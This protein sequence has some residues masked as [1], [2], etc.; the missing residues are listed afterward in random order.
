[1]LPLR[2]FTAV[3]TQEQQPLLIIKKARLEWGIWRMDQ[4]EEEIVLFGI[5]DRTNTI[6]IPVLTD[7]THQTLASWRWKVRIFGRTDTPF[8]LLASKPMYPVQYNRFGV[9][10]GRL[11]CVT[12]EACLLL[13]GIRSA[14]GFRQGGTCRGALHGNEWGCLLEAQ[15]VQLNRWQS[16]DAEQYQPYSLSAHIK[17]RQMQ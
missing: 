2:T 1:M 14:Q 16:A 3:G 17:K 5:L 8:W 10:S 13:A 6:M 12:A 9:V 7:L 15:R 11:Y 4:L